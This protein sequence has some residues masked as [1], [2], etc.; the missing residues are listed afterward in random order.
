MFAKY[1]YDADRAQ[2]K[3]SAVQVQ[4]MSSHCGQCMSCTYGADLPPDLPAGLRRAANAGILYLR[5]HFGEQ[6]RWYGAEDA[7]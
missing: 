1:C 4:S 6:R 2:Y 7:A 3:A 5:R